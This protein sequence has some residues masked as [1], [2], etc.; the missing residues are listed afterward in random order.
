VSIV[1]RYYYIVVL[2][3]GNL[4]F[5]TWTLCKEDYCGLDLQEGSCCG[6]AGVREES[7]GTYTACV[8]GAD[9]RTTYTKSEAKTPPPQVQAGRGNEH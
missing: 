6:R 2:F 7:A 5:A 3:S 4:G 8:A 9:G 1:V